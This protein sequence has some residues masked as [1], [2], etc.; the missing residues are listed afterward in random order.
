MTLYLYSNH[1]CW[2]TESHNNNV[3]QNRH[4]NLRTSSHRLVPR[5]SINQAADSAE[6]VEEVEEAAADSAA[7]SVEDS[8]VEDS[9][10]D[11]AV[12]HTSPQTS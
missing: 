3:E 6:V 10:E 5:K 4:T 1:P 2:C 12:P 9:A 7:D 8:A 11:S